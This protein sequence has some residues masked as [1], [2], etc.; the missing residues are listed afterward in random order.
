LLQGGRKLDLGD[1][2]YKTKFFAYEG[3]SITILGLVE[4]NVKYDAF[5]MTEISHIIAGG[6]VAAS[7]VLRENIEVIKKKKSYFLYLGLLCWGFGA[8]YQYAN[9]WL[10]Q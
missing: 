10:S 1:L 3:S 4:Y 6:Y 7:Q 9:H 5:I 8:A 2:H